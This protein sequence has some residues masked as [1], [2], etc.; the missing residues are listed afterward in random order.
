MPSKYKNILTSLKPAGAL[1]L[2]VFTVAAME[3]VVMTVSTVYENLSLLMV[4]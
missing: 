2:K 1:Q 4:I 3:V